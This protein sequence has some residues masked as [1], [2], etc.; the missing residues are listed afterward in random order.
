MRHA[1][2]TCDMRQ[3]HAT[4]DKIALCKRAY[5]CDMRLLQAVSC[6]KVEIVQLSCDSMQSTVAQISPFHHSAI[7]SHI[8][9]N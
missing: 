5:L 7:L 2:K 4:R 1:T 6:K 8:A 3:K 9:M